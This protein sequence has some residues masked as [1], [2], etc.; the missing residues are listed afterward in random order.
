M[1]KTSV[2]NYKILI[3]VVLLYSVIFSGC[4]S[5]SSKISPSNSGKSA[6]DVTYQSKPTA[7]N[8]SAPSISADR[9]SSINE[10]RTNGERYAKIEENPFE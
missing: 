7:S 1:R 4:T 9:N 8:T 10:G 3:A 5:E 6:P 2:S